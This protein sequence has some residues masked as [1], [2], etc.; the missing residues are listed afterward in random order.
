[1]PG[2]LWVRLDAERLNGDGSQKLRELA[3]IVREASLGGGDERLAAGAGGS[4]GSAPARAA[5]ADERAA[6][7]PLDL[8]VDLPHQRVRLEASPHLRV[9]LSAAMVA[10]LSR[11]LGEGCVRVV[12]GVTVETMNGRGGKPWQK[13]PAAAG[14]GR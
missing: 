7:F 1:M 10:E 4:N 2:K 8:V 11:R 6:A 13:K 3:A 5:S 12:G 9:R 14:A